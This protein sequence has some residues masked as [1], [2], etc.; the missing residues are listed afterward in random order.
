MKGNEPL[1]GVNPILWLTAVCV[2]LTG[3]GLLCAGREHSPQQWTASF[4]PEDYFKYNRRQIMQAEIDWAEWPFA[5]DRDFADDRKA[6]ESEGVIPVMKG[7]D[8]TC[9]A[10]YTED[11][12]LYSVEFKWHDSGDEEGAEVYSHLG[13]IAAP[14]EIT[15]PGMYLRYDVGAS[16]D[17]QVLE[18]PSTV[19]VRD[20]IEIRGKGTKNGDKALAFQNST[21]W[22]QVSGSWGDSIED[23]AALL[24]WLWEHPIDFDRFHINSI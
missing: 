8:F 24:D 21:G 9:E 11:K 14:K 20:G 15:H 4:E 13:I 16:D 7:Y 22:Y 6:L 18:P 17:G 3:I 23:M 19:T 5:Y 1:K 10:Y 2:C 12:R